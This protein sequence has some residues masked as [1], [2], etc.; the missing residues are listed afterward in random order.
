MIL[1]NNPHLFALTARIRNAQLGQHMWVTPH[2]DLVIEGFPRSANTFLHRILRAATGN[3]LRIAHHVHRPQQITMAIRYD[4][5]T[6]V[7]FR[8][9][10]DC[11]ASWLVWDARRTAARSLDLY[12][13]Y[14]ETTLELLG[15]P[16]LRVLS[17]EDV[18]AAPRQVA[19]ALLEDAGLAY[20]ISDELIASA[21]RDDRKERHLSS[22][23]NA[24]KEA[25]KAAFLDEI[26]SL[27]R[28]DAAVALFRRCEAARWRP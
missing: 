23:P 22:R 6:Y 19:T 4:L 8:H 26:V 28:F 13:A 9:P 24:E 14:A 17:F 16:S 3:E 27:P 1:L 20:E 11:I 18:V 2:C 10:R 25:L 7:L 5:P 12:I 21:T 15:A